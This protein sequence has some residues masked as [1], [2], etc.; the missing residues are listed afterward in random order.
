[1]GSQSRKYTIEEE[2]N[3]TFSETFSGTE[4]HIFPAESEFP[5]VS[6]YQFSACESIFGKMNDFPHIIN[7]NLIVINA[8]VSV[9]CNRL[10]EYDRLLLP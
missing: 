10:T 7:W 5:K 8:H 4:T 2:P 6:Q 9:W 1:M 3:F